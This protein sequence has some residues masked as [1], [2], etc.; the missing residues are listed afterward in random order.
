MIARIVQRPLAEQDVVEQALHIHQNNPAAAERFLVAFN[1]TVAALAVM[2]G[3]GAPREHGRI[4]GLRMW[5]VQG[6]ARHL[7]FYREIANGIEV[8]RVLHSSRDLVAVLGED[9]GV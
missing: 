2:P 8:I 5:R 7:I 4:E 9:P 6:F 3:I 1:R